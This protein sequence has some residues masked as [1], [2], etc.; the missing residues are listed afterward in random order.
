MATD[1]TEGRSEETERSIS[2]VYV[3]DYDELCSLA[4]TGLE[5][6][7]DRLAVE[8]TTDPTTVTDRLGDVDCIVSDYEMPEVDGLELL[9]Q[10]RVLDE[11]VPFILFTGEGSENVA[12]DAISLGVTDYL[13]KG[14]G[15]ERFVRL[16]NRIEGAVEAHRASE[17]VQRTRSQAAEAIERERARSRAL[18]EH[19]PAMTGIL[20]GGGRFEYVSP[21]VEDITGYKPRELQGEV[22]FDYVH[23]EDR[24]RIMDEFQR[25]LSNTAYRP[26]VRYRFRHASGETIHLE[27]KGVNRLDDPVVEGIVVN[28]RD[29]TEQVRSERKLRR[30]R[31]ISKRI[32]QVSPAPLMLVDGEARIRR[33][34]YRAA[35]G[36]DMTRERLEGMSPSSSRLEVRTP[37]GEDVPIDELVTSQVATAGV[38]RSGVEY[39]VDLPTGTFRVEVSAAP[40][41]ETDFE[42]AVLCLDEVER[43]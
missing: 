43:V 20:D 31:D 14:G 21:S 16:A 10:V 25:S 3:D 5:T 19:S 15:Q 8:T 1:G 22:A 2:V 26:T 18:I 32:L 17:V 41:A 40:L 7:S 34:N 38:E 24:P 33:V 35:E 42:A 36:F 4:K 11:D 30:E 39:H 28:T 6:A 29:V 23:E 9:R 27:T 37:D 12:S 13:T